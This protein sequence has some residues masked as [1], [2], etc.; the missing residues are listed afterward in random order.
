MAVRFDA[1]RNSWMFVIDLPP[2]AD[3]RRRQM[4][5][6][7]FKTE[8]Q[9]L[10]E[11]KLAKEQFRNVWFSAHGTLLCTAAALVQEAEAG[12]HADELT[13]LLHVETKAALA[14]LAGDDRI[15]PADQAAAETLT[16]V[17]PRAPLVARANRAYVR[18][19][20]EFVAGQGVR[21]FLDIGSGLPTQVNV[22][23]IV[24]S[25]VEDGQVVYVDGDPVAVGEYQELVDGHPHAAAIWGDLADPNVVLDQPQVQQLLDGTE[26]V[27]VVLAAVLHFLPDQTA[28]PA[29]SHLVRALPAQSVV[30]VATPARRTSR[31]S[32]R[33]TPTRSER[34]M[35]STRAHA[36]TC[37]AAGMS[38]D[39]CT[40]WSWSTRVSCGCRSGAPTRPTHPTPPSPMRPRFWPASAASRTMMP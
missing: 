10:R 5:R 24:D 31:M 36:F 33:R 13:A 3:G 14:K 39:S 30:V 2:A 26:P 4:F 7:G 12:Y 21:R 34:S 28:Y 23:D 1:K 22:H 35:R 6:R 38:T 15:F 19:A 8:A 11:E 9:A 18:R 25:V 37:A 27:A 17:L 40:A 29:V 20:V 32:G 16:A